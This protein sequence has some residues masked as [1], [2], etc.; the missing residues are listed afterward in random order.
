MRN[1]VASI[2]FVSVGLVGCGGGGGG[3][4]GGSSYSL[5]PADFV[6]RVNQQLGTDDLSVVKTY[7][8][9]DGWA[10]VL[11]D[12]YGYRAIDIAYLRDL[13]YSVSEAAEAYISLEL[14]DVGADRL[15]R[16]TGFANEFVDEFGFIYEETTM[17]QKDL[18]LVEAIVEQSNVLRLGE[19][20]AADYGLSEDAGIKIAKVSQE[21]E[22]ISASRSMTEEDVNALTGDLFG[23][24]LK[25][26]KDA[27]AALC[28]R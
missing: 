2:A 3:G 5:K 16:P 1:L 28:R 9:R 10:V 4:G 18:E 7:A 20:L 21:W 15:V 23:L 27:E 17:V 14:D 8:V 24:N 19:K 13:D 22:T 26:I 11:D 25:D 12:V 6:S